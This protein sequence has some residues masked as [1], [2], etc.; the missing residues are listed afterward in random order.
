MFR[1]EMPLAWSVAFQIVR[2]EEGFRS[3]PYQDVAGVWTIGY[4]RTGEVDGVA[5]RDLDPISPEEAMALLEEDMEWAYDAVVRLTAPARLSQLQVGALV[6]FVFNVGE[7][8]FSRST[9]L[10]HLKDGRH[11]LAAGEF[12]KWR[13]AGGEIQPGL[14][15]R[16]GLEEQTFRLGI[17]VL[18][19]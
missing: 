6:S 3:D 4:G 1:E 2:Q 8:A 9:M 5:V 13:Q 18:P 12:R 19:V 17:V 11:D 14:L 15:T 7:G 10:R 16:R